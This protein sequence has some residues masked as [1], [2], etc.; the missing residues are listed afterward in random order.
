MVKTLY[1]AGE[2]PS[3]LS[4]SKETKIKYSPLSTCCFLHPS[5]ALSS[6][7]TAGGI[8]PPLQ[9]QLCSGS[10]VPTCPAPIS[11]S[12]PCSVGFF[13]FFLPFYLSPPCPHLYLL[14]MTVLRNIV[15]FSKKKKKKRKEKI[16]LKNR[17]PCLSLRIKMGRACH[18]I[19]LFWNFYIKFSYYKIEVSAFATESRLLML[20]MVLIRQCAGAPLGLSLTP[21]VG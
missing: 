17:H 9:K 6:L 19:I 7:P 3:R 5:S 14:M 11:S 10:M 8:R 13:A 20:V 15:I 21:L 1:L 18:H 12:A 16:K 2:H 4:A